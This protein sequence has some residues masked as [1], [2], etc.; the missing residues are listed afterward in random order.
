MPRKQTQ[1]DKPS[2]GDSALPPVPSGSQGEMRELLEV[3]LAVREGN[4]SVR[5]PG[6]WTGLRKDRGSAQ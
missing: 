2:N 1:I 4:F 6:H 3:L 5:L